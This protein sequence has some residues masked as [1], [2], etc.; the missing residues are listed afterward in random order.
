MKKV[1]QAPKKCLTRFIW[2]CLILT[3]LFLALVG[4]WLVVPVH[5]L[6]ISDPLDILNTN[7]TIAIGE[8]IIVR[9][10]YTKEKAI[11]ALVEPS[12]ECQSGNLATIVPQHTNLPV[13]T[14]TITTD[15]IKLS[16]QVASGDVCQLVQKWTY[17][18]NP[19]RKAVYIVRS[20]YFII[21]KGE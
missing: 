20:E 7:D 13:G 6:K 14:H 10:T 4:Y 21:T 5:E 19:V 11:P 2:L 15:N 3:F 1:C 12:I 17:H 8:P 16:P 9:F 18:I